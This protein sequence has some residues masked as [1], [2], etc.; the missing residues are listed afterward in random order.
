M[1]PPP[2]PPPTPPPRG[3]R[4]R[5]REIFKD[6]VVAIAGELDS[7]HGWA[8]ADVERWVTRWGGTFS[9]VVDADVTHLLATP[10]QF[11]RRV[12]R[13]REALLRRKGEPEVHVV[14]PEWL[15]H[16]IERRRRLSEYSHGHAQKKEGERGRRG[17]EKARRGIEL[18]ERYVD[19]NLYHV[20]RD[21]TFFEHQ[22]TLTRNDEESGNVG[23]KYIMTLWESNAKPHLYI[24]T[25]K[26]WKKPRDAKPTIYRPSDTPRQLEP[27]FAAFRRFFRSRTGLVWDERVARAGTTPACRFQYQPPTRG[28]PVGLI[29]GR[30]PSIFGEGLGTEIAIADPDSAVGGENEKKKITTTT[31][32]K[33]RKR[34]HDDDNDNDNTAPAPPAPKKSRLPPAAAK[35]K[36]RASDQGPTPPE[37]ITSSGDDDDEVEGGGIL[38]MDPS[39]DDDDDDDKNIDQDQGRDDSPR[40]VIDQ[41]LA[42]ERHAPTT[43]DALI[44]KVM[45]EIAAETAAAAEREGG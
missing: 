23:Q 33:K 19:P 11:G 32:K 41:V 6:C 29:G 31:T 9:N 3:R 18:A 27:E 24:F 2:P 38:V 30:A 36:K 12:A 13:V 5:T 17:D 45:A 25:A 7:S 14:A 22:I 28:K 39:S 20:Y 34:S 26:L 15:E 16:S 37:T 40:G 42:H 35:N 44:A 43:E 10:E 1:P 21:V 8:V 4:A